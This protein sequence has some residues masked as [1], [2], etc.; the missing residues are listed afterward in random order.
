MPPLDYLHYCTNIHYRRRD[1]V[2][3]IIFSLVATE[4]G[5]TSINLVAET[6]T[7]SPTSVISDQSRPVMRPTVLSPPPPW[8][9]FVHSPPSPGNGIQQDD[10]LTRCGR[11]TGNNYTP[12]VQWFVVSVSQLLFPLQPGR[13]CAWNRTCSGANAGQKTSLDES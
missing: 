9:C 10:S 5:S 6:T 7:N 8:L 1:L 3:G 11:V 13:E 4:R 12:Y 2:Q